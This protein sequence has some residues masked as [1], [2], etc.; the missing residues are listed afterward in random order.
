MVYVNKALQII[1][2]FWLLLSSAIGLAQSPLDQ[3][4]SIQIENERISECLFQLSEMAEVSIVF[5]S[6]I[7]E[8]DKHI[9]LEAE[10]ESLREVL[11]RCLQG[12]R[13]DFKAEG[14]RI[15]LFKRAPK[16]Y[17][18]SGYIQDQTTGER[19]VAAT[20]QELGKG[21]GATTNAYGFF[22]LQLSEGTHLLQISYL[23]YK[24][25]QQNLKFRA[26]QQLTIELEPSLTLPE[27]IVTNEG[28]DTRYQHSLAGSSVEVL[29]VDLYQN[30][31]LAGEADLFRQL[32]VQPG[33]QS[34]AD[35]IGGLHVRGGEAD[36][37]LVLLDG[38]AVYNPSH[39]LG[40]FSVFNPHTIKNTQLYKDGFSANYSGR[41]SSVIDV[42]TREGSTRK[43]GF[44]G[45]ISTLASKLVIEGPIKKEQSGFLLSLRRTHLDPFIRSATKKKKENDYLEGESNYHFFDI[46]AKFHTR[47]TKD[48]RLYLS[49][50]K[51]GDDFQDESGFEDLYEDYWG[52]GEDTLVVNNWN[53][54]I[55]WGNTIASLRWNHLYSDK[56]FSNTTLTYSEFKYQSKNGDDYYEFINDEVDFQINYFTSFQ[57]LIED[58]GIRMDF[59][60][61]HS[62]NHKILFGAG[63]VRRSFEPGLIQVEDD[64]FEPN[65]E[66]N[67][68]ADLVSTVDFPG[69][70]KSTEYTAYL[71]DQIQLSSQFRLNAG[72]STAFFQ[73]NGKQYF[74][75][76]PRLRLLWQAPKIWSA[77]LS[78]N[79]MTQFLHVLTSSGSGFPSDLW[80]PSTERVGP[81]QAWMS[82]FA[83]AADLPTGYTFQIEAYY[84]R[85]NHLI[86]YAED[87]ALPTLFESSGS[88]WEEE[89]TSGKGRGYGLEFQARKTKG[90]TTGMLGYTY[91]RSYRTF[92][93]IN[94]GREFPFRFTHPHALHLQLRQQFSD[95]INFS[96]GW[97]YGS[98]LPITLVTSEYRFAPLDNL[99][100][101]P[102][103]SLTSTNGYTLP[104]Y[105]RL[106][107]S[108]QFQWQKTKFQHFLNLGV[109]NL[110]NKKNPFYL[111]QVNN[112]DFPEDDGLKQQNALPFLPS[113]SYRIKI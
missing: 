108:L 2:F 16:K 56:L 15:I 75:P 66:F 18:L 55:D 113:L 88:F 109:F 42:R 44:E 62:Q 43:F 86:R 50:Y 32:E 96:L 53:Q 46:N 37:N 21:R 26:A 51:G 4:I 72:L 67:D 22:S 38:V 8:E 24:T 87:A 63:L 64:F 30:P 93:F 39:T 98:G 27:I 36:Q 7:F 95:H 11:K 6:R 112:A 80:V 104:A 71:E 103:E 14:Q 31:T 28:E 3:S 61:Y 29:P 81:Q 91:S 54:I 94:E 99:A 20:I 33:V 49:F 84:K 85:L 12:T 10:Q 48:D 17:T 35:G 65:D 52:V 79:R 78:L 102:A 13:V 97:Q 105:H 47:I 68:I 59:E 41:L 90:A 74:S 1:T 73:I 110:Y 60:Y 77:H 107:F 83:L 106:D 58:F 100:P 101:A 111:Y 45:E 76:Q 19:L 9:N 92:E 82:G 57:S 5:N 70:F 89:I 25:A 23:G 69:L 40:L 34:G